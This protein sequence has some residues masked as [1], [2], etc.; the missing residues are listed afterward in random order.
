MYPLFHWSLIP[1]GLF[2]EAVTPHAPKFGLTIDGLGYLAMMSAGIGRQ[3]SPLAGGIILLAGVA[4]V[5]PVEVA[6][7][8]AP[9]S[10]VMLIVLYFLTN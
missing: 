7:R 10:I 5:S 1:W 4:G 2:N 9:A 3:A 8:I 6:K